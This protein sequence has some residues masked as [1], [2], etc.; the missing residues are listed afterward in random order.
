MNADHPGAAAAQRLLHLDHLTAGD[1]Q[2]LLVR[3][4]PRQNPLIG[5][6]VGLTQDIFGGLARKLRIRDR[7]LG[8]GE[9][10]AGAEHH[11]TAAQIQHIALELTQFLLAALGALLQLTQLLIAGRHVLTQAVALSL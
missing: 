3:L 9:R 5:L 1:Q 7:H 4:F 10:L 2:Q 8:H 11:I 6:R